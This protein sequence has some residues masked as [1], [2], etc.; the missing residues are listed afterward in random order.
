MRFAS[1]G[2]GSEGNGL[3]VEAGTTRILIDCGFGVRDTVARLARLGLAPASLSAILVTHEHTDHVGGVPAFAA[4]YDIPVWLTFGTLA[5][6]GERFEGMR[7]GLRLRQPRRVRDR[8]RSR[9][10]RSRCRTTRASRCSSSSPTARAALGVLTDIG[11]STPLRR[12][13]PVRLRCARARVQPRPRPARRGR[14]SAR[15]SS[16]ASRD[17]SAICT[18]R[19][20]RRCSRALDTTP[21]A[22]H[23]RRAS[24]A[25]EQHAGAGARGARR[26]A[27]AA[28]T[29]WIGIADQADGFDWRALS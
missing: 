22:A 26:R 16:S 3:V 7:A 23:R 4:R 1:L 9:S 17:A 19:R 8:R 28:P 15:R 20:R 5:V 29:D 24:F 12:G 6:V 14:L 18:T 13:E 11:M 10:I 21:A 25:A 2:S 27:A